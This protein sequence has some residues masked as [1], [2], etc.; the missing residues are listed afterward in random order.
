MD[1]VGVDCFRKVSANGAR[2]GFFRVGST[3]QI[4]VLQDGTFAF[5]SW[6]KCSLLNLD[7]ALRSLAAFHHAAVAV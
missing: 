7:L 4:T 5:H 3:H 2:S 1:S 6:T